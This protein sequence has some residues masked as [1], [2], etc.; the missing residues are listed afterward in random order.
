ME[1]GWRERSKYYDRD[2]GDDGDDDDDDDETLLL[3]RR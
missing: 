1:L 3:A 2:Y